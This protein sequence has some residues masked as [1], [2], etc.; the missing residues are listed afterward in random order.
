M[1]AAWLLIAALVG[2]AVLTVAVFVAIWQ[3]YREERRLGDALHRHG[4]QLRCRPAFDALDLTPSLTSL[5]GLHDPRLR[6]H[7]DHEHP[8]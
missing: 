3:A 8:Q 7:S 2:F 4:S 1:I 5:P 6:V